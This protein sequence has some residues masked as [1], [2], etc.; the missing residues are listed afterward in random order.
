MPINDSKTLFITL[1]TVENAILA[2]N[3]DNLSVLITSLSICSEC[4]PHLFFETSTNHTIFSKPK[5]IFYLLSAL[6]S[7]IQNNHLFAI[8]ELIN[9]T[10]SLINKVNPTLCLLGFFEKMR[11]VGSPSALVL[12]K[13]S[14][15]AKINAQVK[16]LIIFALFD[17]LLKIPKEIN[18]SVLTEAIAQ[19]QCYLHDFLKSYISN[20]MNTEKNLEI[21]KKNTALWVMISYQADGVSHITEDIEAMIKP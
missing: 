10:S 14:S 21:S 17:L 20:A 5:N 15:L 8:K 9:L 18:D 16:E 13:L 12:K 1:Q 19:G 11:S 4:L 2:K 6:E 7:A 3:T